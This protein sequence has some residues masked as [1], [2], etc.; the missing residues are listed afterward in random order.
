MYFYLKGQVVIHQKG[1]IVIDVNNIGYQVLVS[2]PEDYIINQTYLV[3]TSFFVREDEQY[4]V[5]FKTFEEKMLFTK[6]IGVKGVGPK[7]AISLLGTCKLEE[8]VN[9]INSS[10]LLFLKSLPGIGPK[11]ATQI[12]LDLKGK[13]N[14]ESNVSGDQNLD[15][16]IQALK[17]FGFTLK[18]INLAFKDI[19][20]GNMTCEEYITYG[21]KKLN[22]K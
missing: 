19:R 14:L 20:Q 5:G 17:S 8:L 2:H 4:L 16:A 9:A 22:N 7:S 13:I 18:E 6:L 1:S 3:Y 21:L 11:T 15:D 12:I 10:N